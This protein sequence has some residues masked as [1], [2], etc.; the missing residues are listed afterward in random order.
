VTHVRDLA[1]RDREAWQELFAGYADFYGVPFGADHAE[2]TWSRLMDPGY[3]AFCI[4]AVD[5]DD[6]PVALAHYRRFARLLEDGCGIYLDDLFTAPA[7]RGAGAARALIRRLRGIAA[8]NGAGVVTWIT[9]RDNIAA[10][11]L[12]N[13]LATKTAWV[14][15]DMDVDKTKETN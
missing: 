6:R 8:D 3:E 5:A 12:Y 7:S 1:P 2:R 10:Q 13:S 9:G 15:Y 14:T 4:V 11:H